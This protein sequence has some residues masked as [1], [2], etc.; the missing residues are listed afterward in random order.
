MAISSLFE[1]GGQGISVHARNGLG[2]NPNAF[3]TRNTLKLKDFLWIF[4]GVGIAHYES[5]NHE[6]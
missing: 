1:N 4:C 2:P 3:R 6:L 5:L